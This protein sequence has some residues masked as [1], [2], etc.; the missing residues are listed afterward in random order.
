MLLK[1]HVPVTILLSLIPLAGCSTGAAPDGA[2]AA[3]LTESFTS[4]NAG[5]IRVAFPQS[6]TIDG[7]APDR[8]RR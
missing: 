6:W 3:G 8:A 4:S 5:G 1:R 7:R 2:A